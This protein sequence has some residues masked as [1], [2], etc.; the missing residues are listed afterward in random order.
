MY[1]Q[2]NLE[3]NMTKT[4]DVFSQELARL[5]SEARAAEVVLKAYVD[6]LFEDGSVKETSFEVMLKGKDPASQTFQRMGLR[7]PY[8]VQ[9]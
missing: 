5:Y 6:K 1:N 9:R 3:D 2:N 4:I 8:P 7:L